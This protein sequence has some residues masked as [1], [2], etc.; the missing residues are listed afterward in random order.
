MPVKS[1][2]AHHI[3]YLEDGDGETVILVHSS[4]S[5]NRQWRSL[6]DA[7]KDDYRVVAPNLFGYGETTAWP[8]TR[9]QNLEDQA[10][11]IVALCEEVGG[12]VH[13]VGHSFGGAVALK[14]AAILGSR[15]ASLVMFEPMLAYLLAQNDRHDAYREARELADHVTACASTGNWDV[16]AARFA[17][18]WLGDG[19]W[20]GM[21]EKRRGAFAA[22]LRPSVHEFAAMLSETSTA[23][24]YAALPSKTLVMHTTEA[25]DTIREIVSILEEACPH[26]SFRQFTGAGHMAPLTD[27]DL[28]NPVIRGFLA[29]SRLRSNE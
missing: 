24:Q 9:R 2:S 22:S 10:G 19:A 11:L 16:A 21:P 27:P 6:S 23:P 26:W 18:Y 8:G 1:L 28:V 13:L 29:S 17:D 20:A 3:D 5:G 25:R 15:V 4:V 7:L 12:P 14:A